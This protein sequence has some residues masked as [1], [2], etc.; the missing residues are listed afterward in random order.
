MH[1]IH[2]WSGPHQSVARWNIFAVF[3]AELL[4]RIPDQC[5]FAEWWHIEIKVLWTAPLSGSHLSPADLCPYCRRHL[6]KN[7][8]YAQ[9]TYRTCRLNTSF[10]RRWMCSTRT[11]TL[12]SSL[13]PLLVLR[14]RTPESGDA[15]GSCRTSKL[16][17]AYEKKLRRMS[18]TSPVG[19]HIS[20]RHPC[21]VHSNVQGRS[22]SWLDRAGSKF[23]STT[24][25]STTG[26]LVILEGIEEGQGYTFRRPLIGGPIASRAHLVGIFHEK[27]VGNPYWGAVAGGVRI[28]TYILS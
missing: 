15:R 25:R 5:L 8:W 1:W 22:G 4:P 14:F 19:R 23:P 27:I 10:R 6:F 24:W 21:N 18:T 12:W 28:P 2:V 16:M 9:N 7:V 17:S 11:I 26:G 20:L 13:P 3:N